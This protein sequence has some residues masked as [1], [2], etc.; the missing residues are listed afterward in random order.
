M[1]A[2]INNHVTKQMK[3]K[4]ALI[5]GITGMDGSYLA[6]FLLEQ[7]Y[8][9]Y[10]LVRRTASTS[11]SLWR[12]KDILDKV[13]LV[14]GDLT[15]KSSIDAAIKQS[16]PD[17]I[18]HLAAQS[19]VGESFK[20]PLYTCE[21]ICLG[22]LNV[23][24]SARVNKP[25]ARIYLASTSEMFGRNI[26]HDGYQRETT[27]FGPSSPYAC[28]KVFAHNIGINYRNSYKMFVSMGILF[29]HTGPMR[30][31]EFLEQKV[32]RNAVKIKKGL[33]ESLS[34]GNLDS[35]RDM[36]DSRDYV[37][38]MWKMLQ[39]DKPN[40]FVISSGQTRRMS[41]IVNYVFDCLELDK[42]QVLKIDSNLFR[43]EEVFMLKG[44]NT[45][46][47]TLL[48]WQP[49]ISFEQTIQDMIEEAYKTI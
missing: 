7:N 25:D 46:A 13:T 21:N 16:N 41:S 43:P 11:Q 23:L 15:D 19:H 20:Q 39:V 40:E 48:D 34:L 17:E 36:G 27:P 9:V 42:A 37:K 26:D 6:R 32:V 5:T 35:Y 33:Q 22:T 2:T 1:F 14:S 10:G 3:Q 29:N 28:A 31:C 30:G 49:S 44:D 4:S 24:D 38:A 12:I 18:Y 8:K 47:K 45:K